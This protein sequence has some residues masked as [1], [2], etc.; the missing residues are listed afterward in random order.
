MSEHSRGHGK[1]LCKQ[2]TYDSR[3]EILKD[4][5]EYICKI[6]L[7]KIIKDI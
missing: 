7:Y 6:H 5:S 3:A 4:E 1:M 2:W